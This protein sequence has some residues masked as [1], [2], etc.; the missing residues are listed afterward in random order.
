[1]YLNLGINLTKNGQKLLKII[2]KNKKE[3]SNKILI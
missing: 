1:M 2:I 3:I